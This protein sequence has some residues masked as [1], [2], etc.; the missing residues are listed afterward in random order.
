[1]EQKAVT[2]DAP[3]LGCAE[4]TACPNCHDRCEKYR[5]FRAGREEYLR[6]RREAS[7]WLSYIKLRNENTGNH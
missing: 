7:V 6:K 5:R 2:K 1:M 3:C 4:R